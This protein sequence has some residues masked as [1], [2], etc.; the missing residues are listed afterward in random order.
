MQTSKHDAYE[1]A[2]RVLFG[3]QGR[4]IAA[5]AFILSLVAWWHQGFLRAIIGGAAI[6]IFLMTLFVLSNYVEGRK[7]R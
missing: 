6:Y 1:Q 5:L 2:R 4:I 7:H 3:T